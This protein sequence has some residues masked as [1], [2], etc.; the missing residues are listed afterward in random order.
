MCGLLSLKL[1]T[2]LLNFDVVYVIHFYYFNLISLGIPMESLMPV[3]IS[4]A[5]RVD[6]KGQEPEYYLFILH[7]RVA[8]K[9][10]VATHG[11]VP[12]KLT[13]EKEVY[14]YLT[15]DIQY[16]TRGTM[17]FVKREVAGKSE[18]HVLALTIFD[19]IERHLQ[20]KTDVTYQ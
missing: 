20:Q 6:R 12:A 1:A 7:N 9:F 17:K 2:P 19:K 4:G 15:E 8:P 13:C 3:L 18:D 5:A 14:E 16:P 11:L 10:Q